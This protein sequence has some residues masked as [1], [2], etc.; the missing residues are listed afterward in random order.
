[1]L[2]FLVFP[3]MDTLGVTVGVKAWCSFELV[4]CVCVAFLMTLR[5]QK[6]LHLTF[7][8]EVCTKLG[9]GMGFARDRSGSFCYS[10]RSCAEILARRSFVDSLRRDLATETSYRDL[11]QRP[12]LEILY[13]DLAKRSLTEILPRELL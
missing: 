10:R 3:Q 5:A 7:L 2:G 13:R 11:V 12:L 4:S 6:L 9:A 1:M 8:T